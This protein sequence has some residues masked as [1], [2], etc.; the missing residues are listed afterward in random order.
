ARAALCAAVRR[1]LAQRADAGPGRGLQ[2]AQ[3]LADDA[4]VDAGGAV[5]AA[6]E[7]PAAR[8][9][10]ARPGQGRAVAAEVEEELAGVRVPEPGGEL[11]RGDDPM[12]VGAEAAA[13]DGEEVTDENVQQP[14]AADAP[15]PSGVVVADRDELVAA[16]RE[17]RVVDERAVALQRV[18]ELPGRGIPQLGDGAP[19]RRHDAAARR[20][21]G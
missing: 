4:V 9:A 17:L 1:R 7:D 10:E 2:R 12:A 15:D 6:G 3:R 16:R 19:R 14:T 13:V 11:A 8:R 20:E 5:L 21:D 18:E